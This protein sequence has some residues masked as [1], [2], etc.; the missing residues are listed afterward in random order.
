MFDATDDTAIPLEG[1]FYMKV[2]SKQSP[3]TFESV[4]NIYRSD[5]AFSNL[6]TR[7]NDF[8]NDFLPASNIPLP[9]GNRFASEQVTRYSCFI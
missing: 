7:L 5:D 6:R 8:L 9:Q 2:G 1:F 4:E 3:L